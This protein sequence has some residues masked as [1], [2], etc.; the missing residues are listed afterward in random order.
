MQ[1]MYIITALIVC[2]HLA[3]I[4]CIVE[5]LRPIPVV[6]QD[7]SEVR[8]PTNEVLNTLLPHKQC[9]QITRAVITYIACDRKL[10]F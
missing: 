2:L 10:P 1:S 9:R 5:V 6:M 7:R 3:G 4:V 8:P